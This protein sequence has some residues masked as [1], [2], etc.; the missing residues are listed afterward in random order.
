MKPDINILEL[1]SGIGGFTKGL[2]EAGFNINKHY[3]S[4]IDK[5]AIANYKHNFPNAE[6]TGSVTDVRGGDL[7]RP[8][9]IT[10][11]SPCF[12]KGTEVLTE[13]GYIKIEDIKIGQKVLTHTGDYRPVIQRHKTQYNDELYDIDITCGVKRVKRTKE[14]PFLISKKVVKYDSK[15]RN[16][17]VTYSTPDWVKAQDII[18]GDFACITIPNKYTHKKIDEDTAYLMGYYTA[19]GW[20][21][22][23]Q[24]K[25]PRR[26]STYKVCFGM[27]KS[28]KYKL[29]ELISKI[30]YHGRFLNKKSSKV[31]FDESCKNN[32]IKGVISSQYLCDL[33]ADCGDG[34]LNKHIPE[35]IFQQKLLY[36]DLRYKND[37]LLNH[38]HH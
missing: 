25:P 27:H 34:E 16:Y 18:K 9:I 19:E 15:N 35:Y 21:D 28:E 2:S 4:E 23:S 11:G 22:K 1:F 20:R 33:L 24:R 12:I 6:Y 5:H 31:W 37:S 7:I 3:Y 8:N 36:S 30:K 13:N 38:I 26:G 32:G 29:Q 17:I 14:H 10:F